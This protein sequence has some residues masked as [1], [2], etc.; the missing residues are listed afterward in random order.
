MTLGRGHKHASQLGSR[1]WELRL[2]GHRGA[3]QVEFSGV[4]LK[5]KPVTEIMVGLNPAKG[6]G[7]TSYLILVHYPGL[8]FLIILVETSTVLCDLVDGQVLQAEFLRKL[9]AV[10]GFAHAGGS[11]DDQ[12]RGS[13][14]YDRILL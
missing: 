13:S 1:H 11:G 5:F 6:T 10:D 7:R 9:F 2:R 14:H 3:V 4:V 8:Q 12:V